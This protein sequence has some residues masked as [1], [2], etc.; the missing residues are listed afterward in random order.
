[1]NRYRKKPVTVL[2]YVILII[3]TVFTIYPLIYTVLTSFKT[4]LTM[5]SNMFGLPAHWHTENYANLFTNHNIG[6]NILNTLFIAVVT[7]FL[8]VL[9]GC[10]AAYVI[11]QFHL[12]HANRLLAFFILGMLVPAQV[13][14]IPIAIIAK[15]VNGYNNF[16]FLIAVYIATGIPYTIFVISGFMRGLPKELIEA[17]LIDGCGGFRAFTKIVLPLSRP[18]IATMGMLSFIGAWN[19]LA[20]ALIVMKG[21]QVQTVS[22][23]LTTFAGDR[24]SDFPGMCAA[25]VVGVLP[26]MIIYFAFQENIIAGMT[27]GSVKG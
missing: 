15:A 9:L 20:I 18:V 13:L 2:C 17:S 3:W 21:K 14:L 16:A 5:Y 25:V 10:M 12:K 11:T 19:E 4:Q 6:L 23:M 22:L 1:M 26:T 27:A 7:A 8:Q 24:F